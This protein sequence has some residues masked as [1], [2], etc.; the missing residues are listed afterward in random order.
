MALILQ[1]MK[2]VIIIVHFIAEHVTLVKII[3]TYTS[4][5][6]NKNNIIRSI[7]GLSFIYIKVQNT[8]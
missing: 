7:S 1:K 6:T 5:F 8:K 4:P 2:L 3:P